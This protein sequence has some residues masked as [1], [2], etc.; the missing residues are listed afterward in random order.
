MLN[1]LFYGMRDVKNEYTMK[2]VTANETSEAIE[3]NGHACAVRVDVAGLV[4]DTTLSIKFE[5]SSDGVTFNEIGTFPIPVSPHGVMF[6]KN[7]D[8]VRYALIV[9]GT[10][11]NLDVTLRF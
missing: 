2:G 11:P 9:G 1:H 10:T 4:G 5:E 8:Y 6:A 7:K 3:L